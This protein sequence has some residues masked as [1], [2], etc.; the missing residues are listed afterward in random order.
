MD[1]EHSSD[2]AT[3][4][5]HPIFHWISLAIGI[6]GIILAAVFYFNSERERSPMFYVQSGRNIIVNR[7][8]AIGSKLQIL[9]DGVLIDATEVTAVQCQ[10]WNAGREPIR[11]DDVLEPIK[12]VLGRGA[13]ILEA[14]V[15]KQSRPGIV[16]FEVTPEKDPNGNRT[17]VAKVHFNILEANDGATIQ[18][19]YT[20]N[21]LSELDFV[22][23]TV[24]STIRRT[25]GVVEP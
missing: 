24:E 6:V 2:K 11:A 15:I 12:I 22:G 13:Q 20:G 8:L 9:Y 21:S 14:N 3:I 5:F 7:N 1:S 16:K 25:S 19:V 17:G 18:I 10:F 4:R 23:A